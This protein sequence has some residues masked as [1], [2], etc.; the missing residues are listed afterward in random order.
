[1]ILIL[2]SR[3]TPEQMRAMLEVLGVYVKLVADIDRN[4]L[5]GGGELH[6]DCEQV[7]LKNGSRQTDLWGA[8]WYP[9]NQTVGHESIINIRPS[10]NNRSM[11][12]QDPIIRSK[13]NDIIY[14]FLGG[15]QWQ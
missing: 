4:I 6:A 11:E 13:V 7:L 15:V 5:A 14:R 12:I 3:A 2:H 8:D 9:F 10:A 1:M